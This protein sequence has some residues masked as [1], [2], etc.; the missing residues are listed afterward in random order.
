MRATHEVELSAEEL[1]RTLQLRGIQLPA[2]IAAF[3]ALEV[4]ECLL[5]RPALIRIH[6][7]R[8]DEVGAVLC[9]AMP[10]AVGDAEAVDAVLAM[11]AELLVCAGPAVPR[12]MIELIE[13]GSQNRA[14]SVSALHS[15]LSGCLMPLNRGATRRIIAR[16]VREVRKPDEALHPSMSARPSPADLDAQLDALLDGTPSGRSERAAGAASSLGDAMSQEAARASVSPAPKGHSSQPVPSGEREAAVMSSLPPRSSR[17]PRSEP[18]FEA[19]FERDL[20]LEAQSARAS[21]GLWVFALSTLAAVGLLV[22]YFTLG[23][24]QPVSAANALSALG[25]DVPRTAAPASALAKRS[26]PVAHKLYGDLVVESRPER[27]QVMLRI[28]SGPALATD[29]PLGIAHEFVALA[30]GYAPARAVVPVDAVWE[31]SGEPRYELAIQATALRSATDPKRLVLG[32]SLLP[33]EPG[34]PQA[35]L[36][37][38]RVITTPPAAAVYQ[39]VGF[40]PDVRVENLALDRSYELLIYAEGRPPVIKTVTPDA[41]IPQGGKRTAVIDLSIPASGSARASD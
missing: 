33:R 9:P 26:N 31:S 3:I 14:R 37:S 11:F 23:R 39:L 34:V 13:R 22:L 2:E 24:Q 35:R 38:V 15:A 1:L 5:D 41:F 21:L 30:D 10:Q 27:A 19:R 7:L 8:L 32:P 6:D 12:G 4:C 36:G 16:L 40:T 20:L 18:R 17:R 29:L 25:L 28:G